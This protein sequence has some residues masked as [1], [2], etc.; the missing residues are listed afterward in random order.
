MSYDEEQ[1]GRLLRRLPPAPEG[2]VRAAQELPAA[3][4]ALDGL[5]ARAEA[6]AELRRRILADLQAA[7]AAEG[8]EPSSALLADLRTRLSTT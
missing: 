4:A 6:D 1:L 5:V 8:I 7:L 3:R 2:W